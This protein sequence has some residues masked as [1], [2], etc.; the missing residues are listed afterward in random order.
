MV[1]NKSG[2]IRLDVKK[3]TGAERFYRNNQPLDMSLPN[4][5]QW[6]TSDLASNAT[7]GILA[8][9]IV[10]KALGITDGVRGEWDAYDLVTKSGVKIEVKSAAYLQSWYQKKL[11]VISF[12]IRPTRMWDA[13]ANELS[14]ELKRQADIYVFSVLN[15]KEKDSLDPLNLDQWDFYII[16]ASV[17]DKKFPSQRSV[18]LASLLKLN[19]CVAK[20]EQISSCIEKLSSCEKNT[21]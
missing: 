7:R 3:K 4:F 9:Y 14:K 5:W 20:Y 15:P 12:G 8:E 1:E 11:S 16:L 6:F 10:A 17:L 2:F 18:R 21:I 13:N 19:P